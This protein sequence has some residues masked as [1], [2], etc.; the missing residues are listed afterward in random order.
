MIM[1]FENLYS[2]HM[3]VKYNKNSNGTKK[4][5]NTIAMQCQYKRT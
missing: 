1:N 5:K 2:P 4:R 3:I